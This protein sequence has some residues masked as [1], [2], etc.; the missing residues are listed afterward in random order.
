MSC[1]ECGVS[2]LWRCTLHEENAKFFRNV[3][4][5]IQRILLNMQ[6]FSFIQ[7]PAKF[8][9]CIERYS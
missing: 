4:T 9:I 8:M 6:N 5:D 1:E 3:E 2:E 7:L